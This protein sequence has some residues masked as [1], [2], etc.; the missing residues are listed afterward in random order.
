MFYCE[1]I[2]LLERNSLNSFAASTPTLIT[3]AA[4]LCLPFAYL[5]AT[6]RSRFSNFFS[7][8]TDFV[9]F[10]LSLALAGFTILSIVIQGAAAS[11]ESRLI[12]FMH[13]F[14]AVLTLMLIQRFRQLTDV[15]KLLSR[16]TSGEQ[17]SDYSPKPL[18]DEI[19][20]LS[21]DNLIIG[22]QLKSELQSVITLL[23]D[24]SGAANYGI[25]IPKGILLEGPPG[26]GKTTLAKVVA[27]TAGLAFFSLRMDEVIS[28]WVGDSE[29]N[30]SRL[31]SAAQSHAPS[32]IFIDEVDS[33]GKS[34]SSN[35]AAWADNLLNH[36]LQLIDGVVK[37]K[38]IYVIAATNRSE[39]VDPALKRPGRLNK[40]ILVPLPNTTNRK[41]MFDLH[42]SKL[43]L[44]P[45]VDVDSLARL[46]HGASGATIKAIC[47]Q[48]G[49][50]AFQRE[51]ELPKKERSGIVNPADLESALNE[52]CPAPQANAVGSN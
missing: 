22:S 14:P 26:T 1:K 38:G 29:K 13:F 8:R 11:A 19:E 20:E 34:R 2:E 15:K 36:L 39:L 9:F 42:L 21:W 40:V 49:L 12:T 16:N 24:P 48:A 31:F 30:L 27:N 23:K 50:N 5:A 7:G 45:G 46:T 25:D 6:G 32:V 44:A 33:I 4:A 52:F 35:S 41:R 18:N 17:G 43:R 28:K 10:L 3:L 51:A 37:T 47:N